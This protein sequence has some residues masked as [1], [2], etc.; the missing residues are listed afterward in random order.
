MSTIDDLGYE[1]TRT[2]LLAAGVVVLVVTAVVTLLRG[3]DPI[4][5]GGVV[6]FLPVLIA[7]VVGGPRAGLIAGAVAAAV[8]VLL[9]AQSLPLQSFEAILPTV[10]LRVIGYLVFGGLGGWAA[11]VLEHGID[12]LERFDTID[13]ATELLNA[14]GVSRQLEQEIARARRYGSDF[15]VVVVDYVVGDTGRAGQM[16]IGDAVRASIRTVDD[17]G[18]VSIGDRDRVIA[19]LPETNPPGAQVVGTKIEGHLAEHI[20]SDAVTIRVLAH[21]ED[22]GDLGDLLAE[23]Q[24]LVRRDFPTA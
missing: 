23:L 17:L 13:D 6:L 9:R 19:V 8:Y 20:A 24:Q 10:S 21:P 1:R 14:R 3:V 11:D 16:A 7:A 12:K 22:D 4:E 5:V 18:R 15:A 2:L